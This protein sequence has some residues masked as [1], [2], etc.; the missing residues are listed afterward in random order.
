MESGFGT[1]LYCNNEQGGE[2][3]MLGTSRRAGNETTDW[4]SICT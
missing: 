3:V 1:L 2:V 4:L